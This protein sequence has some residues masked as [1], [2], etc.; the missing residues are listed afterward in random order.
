MEHFLE[1]VRAVNADMYCV[2]LQDVGE[3]ISTNVPVSTSTDSVSL[4]IGVR[5][6]HATADSGTSAEVRVGDTGHHLYSPSLASC[7]FCLFP[8]WIEYL[9]RHRFTC[10]DDGKRATI[11]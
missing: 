7:G 9:S 8:A 10:D 3:A 11:T 2:T 1:H 4:L 5:T 6:A